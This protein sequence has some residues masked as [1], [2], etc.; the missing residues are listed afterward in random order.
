MILN[1]TDNYLLSIKD[2]AGNESHINVSIL[3]HEEEYEKWD[4]TLNETDNTITLNKYISSNPNVIV[5]SN[6]DI[7]G[8][9]Y[10]TKLKTQNIDD[11]LFNRSKHVKH[12]VFQKNIDTSNVT[13]TYGMFAYCTSLISVDLS[14]FDS[15]N[16]VNMNLMF[17]MCTSLTSINF[18]NFN[19]SNVETMYNV[20]PGCTSLT[21][22]DLSSFDTCNVID[23]SLM[24]NG[25]SN[26]K[27]IY[28]SSDKWDTSKADTTNMFNNCGCSNVTYKDVV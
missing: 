11:S 3:K 7:N 15:S 2:R 16:V 22:L 17:G 21:S 20:F 25:C 12:I 23:M 18:S 1:P 10:K 13:K 9:K 5:F 19:T 6:Y 8:K 14:N 27:N 4:Y 26:L 28:V 24:F